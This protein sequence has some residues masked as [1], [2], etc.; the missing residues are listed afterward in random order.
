MRSVWGHKN[1]FYGIRSFNTCWRVCRNALLSCQRLT[2]VY[3][4]V[5][6]LGTTIIRLYFFHSIAAAAVAPA[7]RRYCCYRLEN[8]MPG[9]KK[10]RDIC[11]AW[12]W[13]PPSSYV[14][15]AQIWM[16]TRSLG[17]V[18]DWQSLAWNMF[19]GCCHNSG[20]KNEKRNRWWS[21][22]RSYDDSK[23]FMRL[24]RLE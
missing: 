22:T 21:T 9:Q 16:Q 14:V 10:K 23:T 11:R 1:R 8:E 2:F 15:M 6:F 13:P 3:L 24:C 17:A 18:S 5:I 4:Y 19:A 7:H 12:W 20:Q